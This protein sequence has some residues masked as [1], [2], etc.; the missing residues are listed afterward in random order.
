[1]IKDYSG[2]F[3]VA[4]GKNKVKTPR[5]K[6]FAASL[7]L[8]PA[9]KLLGPAIGAMLLA[10][11][12]IGTG[13]TIWYGM[14]VQV[15]L[16]QIGDSKAVNLKLQNENRLLHIQHELILSRS[17]METAA[18]KLGLRPPGKNQLRHP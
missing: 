14:K 2:T 7:D 12:V 17:Q 8:L 15:A 10:S 3:I 9:T 6:S 5:K 1:M 18:E 4:H 16:D 13:S 11:L